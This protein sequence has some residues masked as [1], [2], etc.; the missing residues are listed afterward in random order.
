MCIHNAK[1]IRFF[2][3]FD[4]Y[5]MKAFKG[6]IVD[7]V[8]GA[9]IVALLLFVLFVLS[10][11]SSCTITHR[12]FITIEHTQPTSYGNGAIFFDPG[13]TWHIEPYF[14][15]PWER[16]PDDLWP[17]I[18]GGGTINLT[19]DDFVVWG[20]DPP[21]NL[22]VDYDEESGMITISDTTSIDSIVTNA[23]WEMDIDQPST[24]TVC[25]H[26]NT[27]TFVAGDSK[28]CHCLDCGERWNG[29]CQ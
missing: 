1:G 27:T 7:I 5:T 25:Q 28:R 2:K 29:E 13:S 8:A 18:Q 14:E 15:E 12:H 23:P 22:R 6:I 20:S 21:S 4:L 24:L 16:Q 26:Y 3:T 11:L 9:G 10:G 17:S 19:P